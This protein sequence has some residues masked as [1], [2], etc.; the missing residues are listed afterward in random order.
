MEF[1]CREFCVDTSE[2]SRDSNVRNWHGTQEAFSE[3]FL[4]LPGSTGG[5]KKSAAYAFVSGDQNLRPARLSSNQYW[6]ITS[7][8]ITLTAKQS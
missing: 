5:R 7:T 8:V 6:W 4:K 3:L 1:L 2:S